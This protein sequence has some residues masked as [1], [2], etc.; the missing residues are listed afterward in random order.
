M[1]FLNEIVVTELR[2]IL[3]Q[4]WL[5]GAKMEILSRPS[6]GF[7]ITLRG[8][9][10]Y[11][12]NGKDIVSEP[13]TVLFLPECASYTWDCEESGQ[14][15]VLNFHTTQDYS[16]GGIRQIRF[17]DTDDPTYAELIRE[18]NTVEKWAILAGPTGHAEQMAGLYRLILILCRQMQRSDGFHALLPAIRHL[19]GNFADPTLSNQILSEKSHL[20]EAHFRKLFKEKYGVPPMQYLGQLRINQAKNLLHESD[21]P[22][23]EI[24]KR[25]GF[26]NVFSFCR[27]F[28]KHTGRTPTA[29]RLEIKYE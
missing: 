18:H 25:C 10:V 27:S 22:V 21:I 29:Y 17:H 6:C 7:S 2:E 23:G 4:K 15:T 11:H 20:S 8:R 26:S 5:R 24:A 1:E 9:I 28:R 14:F 12:E 19:E 13:G 3:T 16:A